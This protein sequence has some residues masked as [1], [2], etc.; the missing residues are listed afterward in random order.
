MK[1]HDEITKEKR[2]EFKKKDLI[3]F[4]YKN[5]LH[6]DSSFKKCVK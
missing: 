5:P 6:G 2:M 4:H 1:R 3:F